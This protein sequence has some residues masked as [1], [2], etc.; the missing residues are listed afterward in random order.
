[1]K[2]NPHPPVFKA[3]VALE[4]LKEKKI[5]RRNSQPL[6][7]PSSPDTGLEGRSPKRAGGYLC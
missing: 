3:R 7:S 6:P 1:M 2:K 5:L 4:S